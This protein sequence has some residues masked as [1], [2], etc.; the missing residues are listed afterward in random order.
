MLSHRRTANTK[1]TELGLPL[2]GWGPKVEPGIN[3]YIFDSL[4]SLVDHF[5]DTDEQR[6]RPM[7]AVAPDNLCKKG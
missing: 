4:D 1:R 3:L 6:F 2:F 5:S 7:T